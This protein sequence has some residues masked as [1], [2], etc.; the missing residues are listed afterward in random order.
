MPY[1]GNYIDS[2]ITVNLKI[3]LLL[4]QTNPL[5]VWECNLEAFIFTDMSVGKKQYCNLMKNRC[6]GG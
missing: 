6:N 5:L 3:F 4:L 2:L 1:L